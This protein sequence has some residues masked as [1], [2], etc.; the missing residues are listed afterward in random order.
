MPAKGASD[1]KKPRHKERGE[2]FSAIREAQEG[3]EALNSVVAVSRKEG[4]TLRDKRRGE[5]F[6]R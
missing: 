4:A 3:T 1:L 5:S 2:K 6:L